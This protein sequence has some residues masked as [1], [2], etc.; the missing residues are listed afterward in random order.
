LPPNTER[1][2]DSAIP[3]AEPRANVGD[4]ITDLRWF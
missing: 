4:T 1:S 3:A 2:T